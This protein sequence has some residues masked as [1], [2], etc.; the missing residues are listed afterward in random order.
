MEHVFQVFEMFIFKIQT[1]YDILERG[2][3]FIMNRIQVMN[4]CLLKQ[5]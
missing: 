3:D 4:G 2:I 1:K 5:T